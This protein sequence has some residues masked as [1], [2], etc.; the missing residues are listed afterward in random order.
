MRSLPKDASF[1]IISFGQIFRAMKLLED[2]VI[3]PYN[4][5]TR[6]AA[7]DEIKRMEANLGGT[8][9]L[10]PL[11]FVQDNIVKDSSLK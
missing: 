11:K 5:D 6:D 9:I 10:E 2:Q 4:D 7:I 3:H 8:E 1:S